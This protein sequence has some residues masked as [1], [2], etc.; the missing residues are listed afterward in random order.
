MSVAVWVLVMARATVCKLEIVS[1][2][3]WAA[4]SVLERVQVLKVSMLEIMMAMESLV[5]RLSAPS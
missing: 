4:T 5:G 3:G 1:V 2:S